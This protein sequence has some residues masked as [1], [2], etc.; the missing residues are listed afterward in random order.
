M[1][2]S[3]FLLRRELVALAFNNR[4][5]H[6]STD[7]NRQVLGLV[8]TIIFSFSDSISLKSQKFCRGSVS[9]L[10]GSYEV[11]S[12]VKFSMLD[13]SYGESWYAM[14]VH[15]SRH[16]ISSVSKFVTVCNSEFYEE[17]SNTSYVI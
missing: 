15:G 14:I 7:L 8:D 6:N 3:K 16:R 1:K 5:K 9:L 4:K 10:S 17:P 13:E 11:R 2:P 12:E